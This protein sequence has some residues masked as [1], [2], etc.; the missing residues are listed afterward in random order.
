MQR[1]PAGFPCGI[2][3]MGVDMLGA[4]QHAP[5]SERQS[6]L[7]GISPLPQ[8]GKGRFSGAR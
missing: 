5:H 7:V 2:P 8:Q 4:M 6:M 3:G 1:T